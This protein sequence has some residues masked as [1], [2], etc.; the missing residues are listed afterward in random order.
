M[1]KYRNFVIDSFIELEEKMNKIWPG[2]KVIA[3]TNEYETG[4]GAVLSWRV[5]IGK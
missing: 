4:Q 2:W 1:K 3:I 5:W